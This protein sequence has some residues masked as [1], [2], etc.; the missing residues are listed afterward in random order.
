MTTYFA[1]ILVSEYGEEDRYKIIG[2]FTVDADDP[3]PKGTLE[4]NL[5][6]RGDDV[7]RVFR[8]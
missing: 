2:P 7:I 5:R 4:D 8:D 1:E 6:D 3:D